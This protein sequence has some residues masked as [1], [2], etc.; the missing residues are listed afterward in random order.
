MHGS[1]VSAVLPDIVIAEFPGFGKGT[2]HGW[3]F[4]Y[5]ILTDRQFQSGDSAQMST[6]RLGRLLQQ[7]RADW[8]GGIQVKRGEH[9]LVR[10]I[11]FTDRPPIWDR[12]SLVFLIAGLQESGARY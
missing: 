10:V 11:Q 2:F 7:S 3:Y 4:V 12:R 1:D 8:A 6:H 9:V 5:P